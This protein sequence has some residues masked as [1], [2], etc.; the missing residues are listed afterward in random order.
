MLCLSGFELF[1][2]A[3]PDQDYDAYVKTKQKHRR[4]PN[5]GSV[6]KNKGEAEIASSSFTAKSGLPFFRL[7]T[8]RSTA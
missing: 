8:L 2:L 7:L 4:D 5:G 6:L 3:A 1:S